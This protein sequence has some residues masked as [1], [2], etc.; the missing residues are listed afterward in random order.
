MSAVIAVL[1]TVS[2]FLVRLDG[3]I[4]HHGRRGS[5]LICNLSACQV[6]RFTG[7][8]APMATPDISERPAYSEG[9]DALLDAA[10]HVIAR[11]GFRGLTYRR[12]GEEAG[13]THGL[14]SYHFGSRDG[15]IQETVARAARNAM[16]GS[17]L[18][19][20]S[21]RLEDFARDLPK[22]G[23]EEPDAQALQF[24][25]ALEGRRRADLQPMVRALYEEY[26]AVVERAL[27]RIGAEG[28]RAMA[29][30]VFAALDGIMLQQ[31][32]FERREDTEQLVRLLQDLLG[33]LAE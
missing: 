29:R 26:F 13:V 30:L 3:A 31:L 20:S 32:I 18:D 21:G 4:D 9:R 16:E 15:L 7:T 19:P 25:L 17:S 33:R 24:E 27:E 11:H 6:G 23:A 8:L 22:L 12:V 2:P 28:G 10:E 14:V 5:T 1:A